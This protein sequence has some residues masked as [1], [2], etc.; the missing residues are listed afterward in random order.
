MKAWIEIRRHPNQQYDSN[1]IGA[2]KGGHQQPDCWIPDRKPREGR[3]P[4]RRRGVC[5]ARE[6]SSGLRRSA[7]RLDEEAYEYD[8]KHRAR[9]SESDKWPAPIVSVR[10]PPGAKAAHDSARINTGL[11]QPQRARARLRAVVIAHH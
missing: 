2:G 3:K 1:E 6:R 5:C 11:V 4:R 7:D 10:D 8:S 9:D